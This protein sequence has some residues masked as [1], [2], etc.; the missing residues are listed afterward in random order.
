[1]SKDLEKLLAKQQKEYDK[2]KGMIEELKDP[3]TLTVARKKKILEVIHQRVD[4][5]W[6][7]ILC[8]V[9]SELDWYSF[10]NDEYAYDNNGDGSDGG[11]FDVN[12]YEEWIDLIGEWDRDNL[13]RYES[14]FPTHFLYTNYEDELLEALEEDENAEI[15]R[16]ERARKS[17]AKHRTK[18]K[19]LQELSKLPLEK[20]QKILEDNT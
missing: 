11:E 2:I 13:Y 5:V 18:K 6:K 3:N 19:V 10:S 9:N 16:K 20:L 12:Q 8:H 7:D 15:A 14:G 1:M 17:A 4:E